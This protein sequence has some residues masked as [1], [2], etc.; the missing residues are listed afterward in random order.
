MNKFNEIN[1]RIKEKNIVRF[2]ILK[3]SI[4][5]RNLYKILLFYLM[6]K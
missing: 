4:I 1:K 6:I 5:Y 3:E 2:N